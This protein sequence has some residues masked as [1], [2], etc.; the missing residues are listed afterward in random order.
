MRAPLLALLLAALPAAA[1]SAEFSD[2]DFGFS[3][4]LPDGLTALD[5][6]ARAKLPGGAEANRN[7]PR[8]EAGDKPIVH[9][10]YWVDQS[11]PYDRQATLVLA[12]APPPWNPN[13]PEEFIAAMTA[14]GLK[15]D[16]HELIKPPV[17]GLR[18]EGTKARSDGK[19]LR[20]T[21]L[22]LPDLFGK[23]YGIVG[24]QAFDSDW[25]I[26]KE[27]F[28]TCLGSVKMQRADPPKELIEAAQQKQAAAEAA[29]G[30]AEGAGGPPAPVGPGGKGGRGGAG[31]GKAPPPEVPTD[32][33]S[34]K[35]AGSFALAA[36]L[37][38]HLLLSGRGK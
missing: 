1:Q 33:A 5:E 34:L 8:A 17:F 25:N 14:E 20:K 21:V 10:Y 29:R 16:V 26:V 31:A 4:N 15:V 13:K 32:W 18:I 19:V 28:L 3:I 30:S 36:A 22:Y 38:V 37:L 2:P 6:A 12:D 27:Q 23:R 11:S 7:V 9:R 24:F 35:V